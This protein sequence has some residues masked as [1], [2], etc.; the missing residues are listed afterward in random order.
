MYASPSRWQDALELVGC[1]DPQM[2]EFTIIHQWEM[3]LPHAVRHA[4]LN[5]SRRRKKGC[6]RIIL[7]TKKART[8][9]GEREKT[10][11]TPESSYVWEKR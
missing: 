8:V 3:A 10:L 9:V 5:A 11:L 7:A 6:T 4:Q 2:S 1:L